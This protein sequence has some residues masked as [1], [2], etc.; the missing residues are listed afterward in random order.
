M[1]EKEMREAQ[2]EAERRR[3]V[4][5]KLTD[6]RTRV[7]KERIGGILQERDAKKNTPEFVTKYF[8][9]YSGTN[10]LVKNPPLEVPTEVLTRMKQRLEREGRQP[11]HDQSKMEAEQAASIEAGS[12]QQRSNDLVM[13]GEGMDDKDNPI[14]ALEPDDNLKQ[15]SAFMGSK[16]AGTSIGPGE[17]SIHDAGEATQSGN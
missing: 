13:V 10:F 4:A 15:G 8:S 3:V 17:A 5:A 7:R 16:K 9:S 2:R 12:T 6:E 1:N 11:T 14:V